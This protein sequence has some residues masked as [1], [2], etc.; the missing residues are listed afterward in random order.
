MKIALIH[1]I[2]H[3]GSTW[4]YADLICQELDK[5]GSVEKTEFYLPRDMP[6]FCTGCYNCFYQG[7][8]SCPHRDSVKPIAEAMMDAD[9]IVLT[10]PV[11]GMDVTGQMKALLDHLCYLW[12]SHR[13]DPAMFRKVGLIVSTTAGAGLGHTAKTMKNS[14]K[15]WG[16]KKIWISSANVAAMG[17]QD[18]SKDKKSKIEQEAEVAAHRIYK[19]VQN[20]ERIPNPV[21]R[22]IFF[23]MMVGMEKKNDWN[24]K[25]R[26]H[27]EEKDWLSGKR[28]F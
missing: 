25:D 1:G 24:P 7:E 17:W 14:M 8:E 20:I 16:V 3:Q 11:Y 27:W 5:L 23:R 13:P 10:S 12:M 21:F 9:L 28:P 6:H 4:H 15:F 2:G 22:S 19:S 18:V 26:N